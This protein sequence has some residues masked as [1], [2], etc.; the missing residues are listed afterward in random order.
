M[1]SLKHEVVIVVML[2]DETEGN[3]RFNSLN[4]Y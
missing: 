3:V 4:E 1:V 2:V